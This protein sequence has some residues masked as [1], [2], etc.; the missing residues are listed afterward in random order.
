M[1]QSHSGI[2]LATTLSRRTLCREH[3]QVIL[4]VDHFPNAVPGQFLQVL[5][6][7]PQGSTTAHTNAPRHPPTS[8]VKAEQN[9][10]FHGPMLRRPFSIG[11]LRRDG[12]TSEIVLIGRVVGEGTAWLSALE[13][14]DRVD[15]LGP[16]GRGFTPPPPGNKV[17]LLA[18]GVGLPP[19]RWW[20]KVLREQDH[21]CAM[22]YGAQ[23]RDTLP[24]R[25]C[26]EPEAEG[27]FSLCVEEFAT[28]GIPAMIT[29]DDGSCGLKGRVTDGLLRYFAHSAHPLR[30]SVYA[31][32]SLPMLRAVASIC[33]KHSVPCEVAMERL[34]ACGMGTCQSCVLPVHDDSAGAGRRYALCCTDGPVFDAGRVSWSEL[35]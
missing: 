32:G 3:F 2:F 10:T 25:L 20:G 4:A 30:V 16:L 15:V 14:G 33:A 5:C 28:W 18:G 7:A 21:H 19:I 6:E 9:S 26:G 13:P 29:T 34:M 23:S 1:A 8:G 35:S 27:E 24:V 22:I 17:L 31:C 12:N 11:G